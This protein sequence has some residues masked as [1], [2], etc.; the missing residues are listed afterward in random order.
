MAVIIGG[1]NLDKNSLNKLR[2]LDSS[3]VATS[4][5]NELTRNRIINNLHLKGVIVAYT[6]Y[7]ASTEKVELS[8]IDD[9][10]RIKIIPDSVNQTLREN[11]DEIW[12]I[13]VALNDKF[14][15]DQLFSFI[16]FNN[17][18]ED[19]NSAECSTPMFR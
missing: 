17:D 8:N 13:A 9:F 19:I 2:S 6:L 12:D 14:S 16:L 15:S 3:D 7:L 11:I 5:A 18:L 4:I 10:K 1:I